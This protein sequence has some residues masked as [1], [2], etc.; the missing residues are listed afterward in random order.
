MGMPFFQKQPEKSM[1]IT[2]HYRK[3][4]I[5]SG[6][7]WNYGAV[8]KPH[9]PMALQPVIRLGISGNGGLHPVTRNIASIKI[10][11]NTKPWILRKYLL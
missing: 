10:N 9:I 3:A 1:Y 2:F 4:N 5:Q 7:P 11:T 6:I 8:L